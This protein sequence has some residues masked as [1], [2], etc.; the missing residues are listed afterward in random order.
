MPQ[1]AQIFKTNECAWAQFAIKMLGRTI[2]GIRGF[3]FKYSI[4]KELLYAAGSAAIDVQEGN[5]SGSGTI[6]LLKYE[7]DLLNDAAFAAGYANIIKVPHT[8]INITGMFKKDAFSATR[9][10]EVPTLAF[11][12]CTVAMQQNAKMT[13][14]PLPFIAPTIIHR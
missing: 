3:E 9:I 11:T 8:L 2:Q 6:T 5:E 4:E 1:S 7:F 13:E 14:V 12:D 10:I